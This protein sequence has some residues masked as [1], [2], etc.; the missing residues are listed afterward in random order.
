[1]TSLTRDKRGEDTEGEKACANRGRDWP[2]AKEQ[3]EPPDT[4]A[5]EASSPRALGG[6]T[7]QWTPQLQILACGL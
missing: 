1:M 7:A 2:Q 5:G 3:L 4:E 6:S